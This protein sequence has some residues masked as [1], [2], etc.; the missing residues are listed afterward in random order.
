IRYYGIAL[1]IF[2]VTQIQLFTRP[3][4][5]TDNVCIAM[6]P[7]TRLAGAILLW[8]IEIA[9]QFRIY[10]LYKRSYRVGLFNFAL[11]LASIAAFLWVLIHNAVRQRA[12]IAEAIHLPLPGCPSIHSG[13][14]WLQWVPATIFE[15]VLFGWALYKTL[16]STVGRW[17]SGSSISLY[18]TILRDN[19]LYFF[20]ISCLLIF[21]NLMVVV[22]LITVQP[23]VQ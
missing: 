5:A 15:G 7:T 18:A 17:Q 20:G 11:F 2:D 4:I 9:M 10:A 19:V 1:L 14:E 6:D 16:Q 13:I 12:V 22:R 23:P 3:G 8:A 21:N